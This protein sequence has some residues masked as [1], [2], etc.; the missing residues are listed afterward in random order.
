M[1]RRSW[2]RLVRR[3]LRWEEE[4]KEEEEERAWRT[5]IFGVKWWG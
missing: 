3:D 1:G 4:E 5:R 2:G